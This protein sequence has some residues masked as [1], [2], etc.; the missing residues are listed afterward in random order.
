MRIIYYLFYLEYKILHNTDPG[1]HRSRGDPTREY[2]QDDQM[3]RSWTTYQLTTEGYHN[4]KHDT[5]I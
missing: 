4:R 3:E 1:K 5:S 2:W